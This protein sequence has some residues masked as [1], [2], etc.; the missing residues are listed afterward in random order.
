MFISLFELKLNIRHSVDN[1][2]QTFGIFDRFFK[3]DY[4]ANLERK[5]NQRE[6]RGKNLP[7]RPPEILVSP[8]PGIPSP[9]P[10]NPSENGIND[11]G[12]L[13]KQARAMD[14]ENMHGIG[15]L[16]CLVGR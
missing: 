8:S 5:K 11:C 6:I 15:K 3:A 7:Q 1:P 10:P 16:I 9:C 4:S 14:D 2:P 13:S 12:A